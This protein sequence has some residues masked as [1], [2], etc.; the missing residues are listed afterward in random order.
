VYF[1]PTWVIAGAVCLLI[2]ASLKV[3]HALGNKIPALSNDANAA[4]GVVKA[5]VFGVL[6]L[7][8][9]FS[10]SIASEHY[11]ARRQLV[12]DEANALG[13]AYLRADL[14]RA[15]VRG[16]YKED[17]RGYADARLDFAAAGIDPVRIAET[18]ARAAAHQKNLWATATSEARDNPDDVHAAVIESLNS[19]FDLTAAR[20]TARRVEVPVPILV[21]LIGLICVSALFVG[22]SFGTAHH[23][24]IMTSICFSIIITVVLFA[25]L[26]LDRPRRG[27]ILENQKPMQD[28][29]A[30]MGP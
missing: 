2:F 22:H 9:A 8:L 26:D 15:P 6:G 10:F 25:I 23:R 5:A 12:T 18:D 27:F 30:S 20:N 19:L 13:T 29:R 17:L 28:A 7:L 3:G 24:D 4:L 11:D 1:I 16:K 21:L 14:L